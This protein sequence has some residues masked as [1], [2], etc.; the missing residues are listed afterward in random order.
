[1]KKII[2]IVLIVGLIF[3]WLL[4]ISK[5]EF[6]VNMN[7]ETNINSIV[8]GDIV[9]LKITTN[10]KVVAFN[11]LINYDNNIFELVESKTSGLSV[12]IKE[13]KIACVYV[14]TT[15]VGIDCF[16]IEFK[17]ID[18]SSK[19]KF[20]IE[21]PKFRATDKMQ[22]YTEKQ[23]SGLE[24]INIQVIEQ[25]QDL[26]I[27]YSDDLIIGEKVIGIMVKNSY[28]NRTITK[29]TLATYIR[30]MEKLT[31]NDGKIKDN[32]SLVM[33]GDNLQLNG[34]TYKVILYG[35]SNGDG[36][37]CDTDDIMTIIDNFLGKKIIE[38]ANKIA[39]NLE[40]IDDILDIDDIM[41]MINRY[42]NTLTTDLV[43]NLPSSKI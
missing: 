31:G 11:C 20:S 42:L 10:E 30:K 39:A 8:K 38:G 1:M 28:T 34:E 33:T 40:N 3:F 19:A 18:I 4:P 12:G 17:A 6:T 22:S 32:T 21:Q 5:A 16:E 2:S 14:D 13:N 37:I 41:Q 24:P 27:I 7:L 36:I 35:D 23:I 26:K 43:T 15:G 9:K 29:E 25:P